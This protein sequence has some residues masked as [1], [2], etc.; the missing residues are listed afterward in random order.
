MS[1]APLLI[2]SAQPAPGANNVP[3]RLRGLPTSQGP[4]RTVGPFGRHRAGGRGEDS[5]RRAVDERYLR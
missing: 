2:V 5:R 4:Y 1:G 3:A